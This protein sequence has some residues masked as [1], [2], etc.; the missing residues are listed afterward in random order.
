MALAAGLSPDPGF[1]SAFD[2]G[3]LVS[4]CDHFCMYLSAARTRGGLEGPPEEGVL[5]LRRPGDTE[6][7]RGPSSC[8]H[9]SRS[10]RR[11]YP[12]GPPRATDTRG[13][14]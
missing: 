13:P 6:F 12:L 3:A 4:G 1:L 5:Q 2:M 9:R 14:V 8:L 7:P 11:R 10:L